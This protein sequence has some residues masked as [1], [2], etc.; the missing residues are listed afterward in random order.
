MSVAAAIVVAH[1]E[2]VASDLD[3][4]PGAVVVRGLCSLSAS[5]LVPEPIQHRGKP[6]I[7]RGEIGGGER[8]RRLQEL[9]RVEH[10]RELEAVDHAFRASR[11][12]RPAPTGRS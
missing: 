7:E 2:C 12:R 9:H 4:V 11:R 3:V 6:G 1:E 10:E 8:A 5:A